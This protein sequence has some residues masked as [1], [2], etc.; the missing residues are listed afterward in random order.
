MGLDAI[1]SMKGFAGDHGLEYFPE[2]R[3]V[4]MGAQ[5]TPDEIVD[6]VRAEKADAVL[7][8]ARSSPSATPT[9]STSREVREALDAA[10][11]R[12]GLL[13]VGGGPRFSPEQ[14]DELGYDRIFTRGT[15]PSEVASYL[16]W[17]H[18]AP[19][20]RLV[21]LI[22]AAYIDDAAFVAQRRETDMARHISRE[23]LIDRQPEVVWGILSDLEGFKD[24]NPFIISAAGELEVGS[25]PSITMKADA[26]PYTFEPT[27]TECV[28]GE[29]LSWRGRLWGIPGL[30]DGEHH[31]ALEAMPEGTRYIQS[32]DFRGVLVPLLRKVLRDTEEAFGRMNV[33]L[34]HEAEKEPQGP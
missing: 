28:P 22:L 33:A 8:L 10:G 5:V 3:V 13:L 27:V 30:F 4:N 9:S 23:I 18:L 2:M 7:D 31:H 20:R 12:D 14:A 34:K 6:A 19:P 24:W 15:K 11:L 26:K 25:R 17:T 29:K 32:E 1:L 16:A 21:R